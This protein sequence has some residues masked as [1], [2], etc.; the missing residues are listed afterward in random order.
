MFFSISTQVD[1]RFPNN[2]Q[3]GDLWI[4]CDNGWTVTGTTFYKGYADNHCK[5]VVD[6]EGAKIQHSRPRSF[7]L[8]HRPG[9]VTNLDLATAR[10]WSDDAVAIDNTGNVTVTKHTINLT[11]PN[12]VLTASQARTQIRRL[13]D[14]KVK[15]VPEHIKL[16]C[17]GGVDTLLLYSMLDQFELIAEEHYEPDIFTTKNKLALNKFWGYQQIHHWTEPTWLATG[18]HGDE[19]F[20]RGPTVIA[21]LTAWHGINFGQLLADNP[22]CYH[23]HHFNKYS[24]LWKDSW[25]TRHQLKDQY[26]TVNDLN[27][28]ILN[29]LVNDYQHWH[30]GNTLTWTPFKDI[31]IARILLRCPIN[32]LIPQFLDARLSKDLIIDYNDNI[33]D[34]LSEYKNHNNREN[35]PKLYEYHKKSAS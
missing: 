35:L 8:Y 13:L 10:A 2:H 33:I 30:L 31:D 1:S 28:Q 3:V 15:Q 24:E 26:P 17:S 16:F 25:N 5:I 6:S 18:S 11:V 27:R 12:T 22:N 21:M 34:Y 32:Q 23:Y 9:Q 14:K 4:N 29:I 7:P 20:L 19:Y